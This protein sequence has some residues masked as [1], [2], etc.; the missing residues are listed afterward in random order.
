MFT[1]GSVTQEGKLSAQS[2][3]V[4][5]N[6]FTRVSVGVGESGSRVRIHF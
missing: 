3:I 2:V 4:I 6:L 5:F 1:A